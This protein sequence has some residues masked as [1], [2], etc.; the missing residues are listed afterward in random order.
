MDFLC[1]LKYCDWW[2]ITTK[3]FAKT[4]VPLRMGTPSRYQMCSNVDS[5]GASSDHHDEM[6]C[7]GPV[8]NGLYKLSCS[9]KR[10]SHCLFRASSL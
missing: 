5:F 8:L 6:P 4:L 10:D 2:I 7:S 3:T 1:D 9:R